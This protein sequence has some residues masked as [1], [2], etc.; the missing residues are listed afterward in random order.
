M[1][2]T[3]TDLGT[4][5]GTEV[6]GA[7]CRGRVAEHRRV[8]YVVCFQPEFGSLAFLGAPALEQSTVE[9]FNARSAIAEVARRCTESVGSGLRKG[10]AVEVTTI[11]A[12][13]N[14]A[15]SGRVADE[16]R[17]LGTVVE[18]AGVLANLKRIAALEDAEAA[19]FPAADK[20]VEKTFCASEKLLTVAEGQL[21]GTGDHKAMPDIMSR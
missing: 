21:I 8:G 16:V 19:D 9:S 4:G 14:S 13:N 18:N 1:N 7:E 15:R 2:S 10:I 5:D 11:E 20:A 12:I 3:G 17:A 6:V